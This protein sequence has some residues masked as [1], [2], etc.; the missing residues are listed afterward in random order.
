MKL[1]NILHLILKESAEVDEVLT[2]DS[3][4]EKPV[5]GRGSY[6]KVFASKSNPNVLYKI[7]TEEM[8]NKWV[9]LFR[10][11]PELFPKVYKTGTMNVKLDDRII[12]MVKG[13]IVVMNPGEPV[14]ARYVEIEK[15]DTKQALHQ[16]DIINRTI[17]D[18]TNNKFDAQR[19][20]T[21]LDED[22]GEEVIFDLAKNLKQNKEEFKLQILEDF[23]NLLSKVYEIKP[24][25]DVHKGN[26]G[27]DGDGRLKMLDI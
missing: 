23:Y 27:M 25:A 5:F 12:R 22:E 14:K 18:F 16:W 19:L 7:G 3:T 21:I 2:P 1:K 6:H 17:M 4:K 11:F 8:V 13:E 20:F 10:K 24:A 15:L 26:F 9:E